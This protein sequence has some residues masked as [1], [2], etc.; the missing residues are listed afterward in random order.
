MKWN[1]C[2]DCGETMAENNLQER[3]GNLFCSS[4]VLEYDKETKALEAAEAER[5]KIWDEDEMY[6]P[7]ELTHIFFEAEKDYDEGFF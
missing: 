4:C 1:F 5:D 3:D 2:H 7:E 6:D